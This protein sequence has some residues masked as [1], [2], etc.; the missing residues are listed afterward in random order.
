M[1]ALALALL[2][3]S[4]VFA[5]SN[6]PQF[7]GPNASGISS[8]AKPPQTFSKTNNLLWQI[9][10]P[11]SPSSPCIWDDHIFVTTFDAGKLQVRDY[12]RSDGENNWARLISI[13]ALEEFHASE[14]S[15]A[16]STPAT[17]GRVVV[18]Y[19]GSCGLLAYDFEGHELWTQSMP[20]AQT[21]G[22]F[23][24]GTSPVIIGK[25]VILNRDEQGNSAIM[26]FDIDTGKKLWRTARRDSITSYS[27]PVL[28]K[29]EIVVAGSISMKAYDLEKGTER[30]TVR[31]LPSAACPTPVVTDDLLYFAGWSPGKSDSPFPSWDST[32]ER[33]DKNKDGKI[34]PEEYG[35]P[36]WFKPMDLDKDGV[37]TKKDW[38]ELLATLSKGDNALLAIKPGGTGDITST[39]VAWRYDRGLPYVPSSLVYQDRLYMIKDGGMIS[40]FEAKTGKPI[41]TQERINSQGNY[42]ASPVAADGRIFLASQNGKVTVIKSG[43][44]KPEI[45]HQTDFNEK[46]APTMALIENKIYLRTQTKLY[47]FGQKK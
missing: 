39:H 20:A 37:I 7:R 6:W 8:D 10:L 18:A 43:G 3:T 15:P 2:V 35:D 13:P 9:D 41:Y 1:K 16:A 38:D 26:A 28:W 47:A 24:T 42:Y 31:G 4:E 19:F 32:A 45:L 23:G 27:T 5:A 30:W 17:D 29:N 12:R 44:E 33:M 36:A 40:C 21:A 11:Y 22:G 14:G 34:T 46:I 25:K